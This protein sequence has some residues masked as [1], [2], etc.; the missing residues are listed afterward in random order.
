M[1]LKSLLK[2]DTANVSIPFKDSEPIKFKVTSNDY[3]LVFIPLTSDDI[4]K[5]HGLKR[6]DD[7]AIQELLASYWSR[8]LDI[9]FIVDK[10]YKGAGYAIVLDADYIINRL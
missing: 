5:I 3:G 1:K 4:D 9:K 6:L 7:N 8:E 2:E 10:K